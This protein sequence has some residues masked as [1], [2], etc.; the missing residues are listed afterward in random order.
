[1]PRRQGYALLIALVAG[2]AALAAAVAFAGSL[3]FSGSGA[4]PQQIAV[5]DPRSVARTPAAAAHSTGLW[6]ATWTAAPVT[7]VV[8]SYNSS[9]LNRRTIRDVVH[10]SIGGDAARITLSNAFGTRPLVMD[11]VTVSARPVTFAGART[12]TVAAG[13]QVVSDPVTVPVAADSDLVVTLR[14]PTARGPV[15]VHERSH[16]TSYVDTAWGTRRTDGWRYLTAVD[17]HTRTAA[18]TI[19]VIGDSLTAGTGSS[20]DTNSRWPDVLADR[21]GGRYGVANAG[22]A[23]NRILRDGRGGHGVRASARFDR[24]VLDVAGVKTV[25]VALGIN[26]VQQSPQETDPQRIADGLRAMTRSAHAQGLRVVGATLMPYEGFATWTP[27]SDD[28]RVRVNA[29]IRSGGVFDSVIDFDA[30]ARDPHRPTRLLPAYD[31]GDHLHLNDA[32][33]RQLGSMVDLTTLVPD[34]ATSDQL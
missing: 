32:G 4:R 26:D 12:V 20:L 1:M 14:T 5:P 22:I 23:G 18:G 6:A 16:Q 10:T 3:L 28:V 2:T 13:G 17:V 9:A 31:S 24:D 30:A 29:L 21:L 33:Y 15:T 8:D 7:G 25:V 27:G 11:R 19:A 34:R